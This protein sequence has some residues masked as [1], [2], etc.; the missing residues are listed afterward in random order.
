[1]AVRAAN[2]CGGDIGR[3]RSM[4]CARA[5]VGWLR[6]GIALER[7]KPGHPQQNGMNLTLKKE[8]T[9]PAGMNSLQRQARFD[10]FVQ[11]F[12]VERPHE[13]IAMTCPAEV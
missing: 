8:A 9:R 7:I 5:V 3:L 6:L 11:E 4:P 2:T 12:N 10:D 13:A 1:M